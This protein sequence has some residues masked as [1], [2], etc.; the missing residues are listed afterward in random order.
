ML[1]SGVCKHGTHPH[2]YTRVYTQIHV[3]VIYTS[4][5]SHLY[6]PYVITLPP[7]KGIPQSCFPAGD[8]TESQP[9][10]HRWA[11]C[12]CLSLA[13]TSLSNF[14]I[15]TES[16]ASGCVQDDSRVLLLELMTEKLRLH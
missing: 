16:S 15:R 9:V 13:E 8:V 14:Q 2:V 5:Y 3:C 11:F 7:F 4:V 10:A 12:G 6:T 1:S